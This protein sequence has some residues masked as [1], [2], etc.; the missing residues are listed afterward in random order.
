[1][2]NFLA[3]A[4]ATLASGP[5]NYARNIQYATS[6]R[7]RADGTWRVLLA[8]V[9]ETRE[10]DVGRRW[11]FVQSRLRIGWGTLRVA[12]GM[13]FAQAVYDFTSE[14][15]TTSKLRR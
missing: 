12:A 7:E 2:G 4:L 9:D 8:L 1:M 13:A 14:Q 6:S 15:L 11:R 10:Q 5:F 3:A